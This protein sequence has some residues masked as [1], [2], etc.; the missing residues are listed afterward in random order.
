MVLSAMPSSS[1]SFQELADVHVMLD[2]AVGVLVLPGDAR[3][4]P[5]CTW[6]RKCMR[7]PLHQTNQGLPALC[8]RWIKSM[9]AADG[10]VIDGFHALL[11]QRAG[12]LDAVPSAQD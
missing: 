3:A 5:F 9:A 6:V 12:I 11:G 10:F 1:S 7:V 2:H 4:A 8:C